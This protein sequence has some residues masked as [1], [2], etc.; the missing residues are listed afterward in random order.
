MFGSDYWMNT[1]ESGHQAA[2]DR[3]SHGIESQFGAATLDQFRGGNALRWLG[4]TDESDR[5]DPG[6]PSR[7]RLVSFYDEHPLPQ[8]LTV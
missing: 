4:F 5:V 6:S 7:D 8:W 3:F 1:L 2:Y